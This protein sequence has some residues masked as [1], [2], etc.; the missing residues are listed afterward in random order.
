MFTLFMSCLVGFARIN[1]KAEREIF[2]ANYQSLGNPGAHIAPGIEYG[3]NIALSGLIVSNTYQY[4]V[5]AA[6]LEYMVDERKKSGAYRSRSEELCGNHTLRWVR[7]LA[8]NSLS[9]SS[10]LPLT[11]M[12]SLT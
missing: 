6:G 4:C 9:N 8:P 11:C 1:S 7:M 5:H 10:C 2:A 3:D 12:V